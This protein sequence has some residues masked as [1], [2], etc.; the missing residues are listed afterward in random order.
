MAHF[1]GSKFKIDGIEYE[2]KDIKIDYLRKFCRS[3]DVRMTEPPHKTLRTGTGLVVIEEIK[4]KKGRIGN[5]QP[6]PWSNGKD[7]TDRK[8]T[9]VK[10]LPT[11]QRRVQ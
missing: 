3:N 6:D 9:L 8:P 4:G 2:L 5:N 10:R 7:K 11:R 1:D